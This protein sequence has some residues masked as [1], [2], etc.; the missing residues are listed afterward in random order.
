[1][2]WVI[3]YL[4][5]AIVVTAFWAALWCDRSDNQ[6]R[7]LCPEDAFMALFFCLVWPLSITITTFNSCM[8]SYKQHCKDEGERTLSRYNISYMRNGDKGAITL[9]PEGDLKA[10]LRAH[11]K[12]HIELGAIQI[13][14]IR[15]ELLQRNM[16]RNLLK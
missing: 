9:I 6:I 16:E 10:L 15:E 7:I 5:C 12:R 14:I 11:R 4:A 13:E 8:K 3:A 1:M 2:G